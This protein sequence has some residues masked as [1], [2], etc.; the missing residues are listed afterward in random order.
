MLCCF[1]LSL[2]NGSC[3]IQFC[4]LLCLHYPSNELHTR[5]HRESCGREACTGR[6]RFSMVI[7]VYALPHMSSYILFF[8]PRRYDSLAFVRHSCRRCMA[9]SALMRLLAANKPA[10]D[11]LVDDQCSV[12][13]PPSIHPL[14]KSEFQ[15]DGRF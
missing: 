2:D 12:G 7:F 11:A 15:N 13:S 1:T 5:R 6:Q 8:P 4:P 14:L 10:G 3:S 9:I